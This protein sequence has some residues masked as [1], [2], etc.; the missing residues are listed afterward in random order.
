MKKY[1]YT[2]YN[3]AKRHWWSSRKDLKVVLKNNWHFLVLI[4]M[5]VVVYMPWFS[6]QIFTYSDWMFRFSESLKDG[7]VVSPWIANIDLGQSNLV[8]WRLPLDVVFALLAQD[9]N[10]TDKLLVLWPVAVLPGIASFMLIKQLLN[11]KLAALVGSIVFSFNTFFLAINTQGH[12]L[13]TLGLA[14]ALLAFA[15]FIS[16]I[17]TK[18]WLKVFPTVIL[19]TLTGVFDLR[20][21]YLA[22]F[23][24]GMYA[25]YIAIINKALPVRMLAVIGAG[26]MVTNLYWLMP[27][28]FSGDLLANEVLSRGLFGNSFWS[29]HDAA[30]LH[31]PFWNG[32]KPDWFQISPVPIYFWI[33]PLAAFLGLLVQRR[34]SKV[35]FFGFLVVIGILLA[36][37]VDQPF[38]GLYPWLFE[39]VPGFGAFREAS[40]FYFFIALGYAVLIAALV[41]WLLQRNRFSLWR[42]YAG[43]VVIILI[44]GIFLWNAKPLV[45]SEIATMHVPRKIP[46]D[47]LVLKKFL[48]DQPEKFRTYWVP[49]DSRWGIYTDQHPKLSAISTVENLWK[50]YVKTDVSSSKKLSLAMIEFFRAPISEKLLNS[51]SV[52]YVIVPMQDIQNDDDFFKYYGQERQA[53]IE[54]LDKVEYLQRINI[55]TKE[56]VVYENISY[57]S[58]IAATSSVIAIDSEESADSAYEFLKAFR[59]KSA[60]FEISET[61]QVSNSLLKSVFVPYQLTALQNSNKLKM[62]D[63]YRS[64]SDNTGILLHKN[65][66]NKVLKYEL[67]DQRIKFLSR[68]L[69]DINLNGYPIVFDQTPEPEVIASIKLDSFK[70]TYLQL[71][72]GIVHIDESIKS[73]DIGNLFDYKTINL[74]KAEPSVLPN[75]S[76][77][78]GLWNESVGDCHKYDTNSLLNMKLN[79]TYFSHGAS[80]LELVADRHD[81]C[82]SKKFSVSP[83]DYLLQIQHQSPNADQAGYYLK[84][85]D[86]AN[87]TVSERMQIASHDQWRNKMRKLKVPEGADSAS[88]YLYAYESKETDAVTM[89]Y[90]NISFNRL[91]LI[92]PIPMPTEN[93]RYQTV[94]AK[95]L[96]KDNTFEYSASNYDGTNLISNPSF[97]TGLWE[98]AVGDCYNYDDKA[99]IAMKTVSRASHG[100]KALE[101]SSSRHHA[102]TKTSLD[103]KSW[104]SHIL[105]F[106]YQ[107]HKGSEAGYY[108]QFNNA[109]Q[110]VVSER[111]QIETTGQWHKLGRKINVPS[112]A[113][114]GTLYVYAYEPGTDRANAVVYDNFTF[115]RSPDFSRGY[116][117]S[118]K[119]PTSVMKAPESISFTSENPGKKTVRING[120]TK[121]F[122][123]NFGESYH[124]G[125]KLYPK[126]INSNFACQPLHHLGQLKAEIAGTTSKALEC[127]GGSKNKLYEELSYLWQK[128]L[129]ESQHIV[130][131]G[132]SN[133]WQVDPSYIKK[134]LPADYYK[135]NDDGSLDFEFVLY[136]APQSYMHLGLLASEAGMLAFISFIIL[137]R[138]RK[139]SY[140]SCK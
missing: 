69:D 88:L 8:L 46:Q 65:L 111:L 1:K 34:N 123:L 18:N 93:D 118:K 37:Q 27:A 3:Y 117:M 106:D 25:V 98:E 52:K 127:A 124:P 48:L 12:I 140:T 96:P 110:T 81:A 2:H 95:L 119:L 55:G 102:C 4:I 42:R 125:W 11:N 29:F 112:G 56:V 62:L 36:K 99:S 31:H 76:F 51:A 60:N 122:M 80:S 120:A 43:F 24:C 47:Y 66:S 82:T 73:Q 45:T 70:D 94:E 129:F 113:T 33:A 109:K 72:D 53:Y 19:L 83:G 50:P 128:P 38:S 44:S 135:V 54:A 103:I 115:I 30:A 87:T 22:I 85:N 59:S 78:E 40:K 126:K 39:N 71:D 100:Q 15:S 92:Q 105:K 86:P 136:Y 114:G 79:H 91:E 130:L 77:E 32:S 26:V 28:I 6:W 58:Y 61:P 101:L 138:K 35:I 131:N 121:N 139:Y 9:I 97:E 17:D 107:G 41:Q 57:E 13:L 89:R 75:G 74:F 16:V 108:I 23:I 5:P 90:D 116:Y 84:F 20:A 67:S 68:P 132:Y 49:R 10:I 14:V 7:I 64:N 21:L 104:G 63:T 134:N 137:S 133:A